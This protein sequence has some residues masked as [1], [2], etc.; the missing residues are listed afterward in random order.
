[1]L[2]HEVADE[3][4][5]LICRGIEGEMARVQDMNLSFW[6]VAAVGLGLGRLER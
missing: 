4:R 3:L 1:M 6:D 2:L 5:Y